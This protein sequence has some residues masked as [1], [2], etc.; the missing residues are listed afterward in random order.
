MNI[1]RGFTLIELLVVISIIALLIAILLPSLNRARSVARSVA[2]ASNEKQMGVAVLM[3]MQDYQGYIPPSLGWGKRWPA[4]LFDEYL[5]AIDIFQCTEDFNGD[6]IANTYASNGNNWLFVHIYSPSVKPWREDAVNS[7]AYT[8]MIH[9]NTV[10][11]GY[12]TGGVPADWGSLLA[13]DSHNGWLYADPPGGNFSG[14]RHMRRISNGEEYGFDNNIM[15]DGHVETG[16]SMKVLVEN[17]APGYFF[18][19]PFE[20]ENLWTWGSFPNESSS[21]PPGAEFWMVPWW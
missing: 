6:L 7:P 3:Y 1:R 12:V 2:C 18:S 15:M 13:N 11:L 4:Y 14:G 8:V 20:L 16:V 19:Y 10:D 9:E 5:G 17:R 21:P